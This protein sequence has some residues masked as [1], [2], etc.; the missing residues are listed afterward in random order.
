MLKLVDKCMKVNGVFIYLKV[1]P[2]KLLI[3]FKEKWNNCGGKRVGRKYLNQEIN[4]TCNAS[5][6]NCVPLNRVQ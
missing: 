3:Y 2:H 4:I 5:N 6:G 1:S